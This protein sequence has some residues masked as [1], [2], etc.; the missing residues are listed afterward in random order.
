[1]G[2]VRSVYRLDRIRHPVNSAILSQHAN[3]KGYLR[4]C[5]CKDGISRHHF[6]H[7]LVAAAF[8][9]NENNLPQVNHKDENPANNCMDNLE[10]CTAKYNMNYGIHS[11]RSKYVARGENKKNSK[12][13]EQAVRFIRS[14]YIVG[15]KEYG[16]NALARKFNVDRMT[17]KHVL[18]R[19][20]WKHI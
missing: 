20:T 3:K 18:E 6:V 13:N 15:D 12:L 4:V 16:Q 14:H 9:A 5:I 1:M 2:R 8:I 7:R 19:S 17:I 11:D 10:W